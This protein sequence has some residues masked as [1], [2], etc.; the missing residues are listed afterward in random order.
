MKRVAVIC[1]A[2]IAIAAVAWLAALHIA[3]YEVVSYAAARAE[4]RSSDAWLLDRQGEALSRVRIDKSRRRGDWVE[5]ANVSPALVDAM[6]A[7]EDRRFRSH[8]GVDWFG[9]AGAFR[10]TTSGGRRGG[11]TITMQLAAWLHPELER[12]GRRDALQKWRQI[13][14][15]IAMERRWT[16]DE[17]LEAWLNLT[18]FRGE[19]EG[20]DAAAH[21]LFA[22][23][24]AGLERAESALLAALVRSPNAAA[25]RV[26]QRAC[27]LLEKEEG[28]CA[29][30]RSLAAG[31][32]VP[33][34]RWQALDGDA[35]HLARKLLS[36][37]GERI[38]STLDARVQRFAAA[39]LE[40]HLR[41][42]EARNVDD[43]AIVVLD[44][45]GGEVLAWVG[46][47]GPRSSAA[48]VDGVTARRQPGSALKPFL[49]A[50][51]LERRLLTAASILDDSSLA[52]T[53]AGGLYVPQNYDH[54]F[55]GRVSL[56]TALGASL[57]VPAVRTLALVGYEPFYEKLRALGFE[58]L[59]RDAD[60][61]GYSLALGG[62]EVTLLALANAYRT[63]AN[64]GRHSTISV[65]A[66]QH[67]GAA[68]QVVDPRAAYVIGDILADAAARASTFG[69]A[70]PLATR[71]PASVKTGTSTEMRDNWAV[72]YSS[73]YTVGVWVGNF[74]G[75]P[76]HDVSGV[77]GAAPVWREVMDFLHEGEAP[78]RPAAPA[79][80]VRQPIEYA[81]G[82]EPA[83]DEW[84]LAGTEVAQIVSVDTA[85]G[86]P[87]IVSPANGAVLAID[88][89]IPP[90]RQRVAVKVAGPSAGAR[91]MIGAATYTVEEPVL[92]RP[93]PGR[94]QLRLV[95][96]KGAEIDRVQVTVRGVSLRRTA[97]AKK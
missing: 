66:A 30:V 54:S 14:Q 61:Y 60:H 69:L 96:E 31:G 81:S 55:R 58:T 56:R 4:W 26:A 36:A 40:Q 27:V 8:G 44:N 42:L 20:I 84:F 37:P 19:L 92:W 74:S 65:S 67:P 21:A 90:A 71:Y 33:R 25:P 11:S 35:P 3:P 1:S 78:R 7:A 22:K 75:E 6:L 32:L 50:L 82:I 10:E 23:R 5:L 85:P 95:D 15:A 17:L 52:V 13:R 38:A 51:A 70:S 77:S 34:G 91:L 43:G 16:K 9:L 88:P 47:A 72:G 49:Y 83:R 28:A 29:A 59:T 48:Q 41:E 79:G 57:N 2:V 62:A 64:G 53:T 97:L 24:P 12:S 68:V 80:L 94:H 93:T 46:S 89:D 18:A 76:M 73:R 39:T 87:R 86:R 63:L 45:A